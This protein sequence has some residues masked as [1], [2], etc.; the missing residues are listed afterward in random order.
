[1]RLA[2]SVA[3]EFD[4]PLVPGP[5]EGPPIAICHSGGRSDL[6][7]EELRITQG[8]DHFRLVTGCGVLVLT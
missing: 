1:M 4:L 8:R 5:I 6:E 7:P 3:G 2:D